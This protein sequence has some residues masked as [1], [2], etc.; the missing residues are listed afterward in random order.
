M[1]YSF[2]LATAPGLSQCLRAFSER[3]GLSFRKVGLA[4][5]LD[6]RGS[7]LTDFLERH[8]EAEKFLRAQLREHFPHLPS[9]LS[10]GWSN[11]IPA[12]RCE[13][14]DTN[15]SVFPA[16]YPAD[17]A[18]REEAVYGDTDRTWSQID[19]R[20]YRIDWQRPFV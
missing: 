17:Q 3:K 18:L 20:A 4:P 14:N 11:E 15:P 5:L 16:L 7:A 1:P 10:E 12:A 2:H 19:N 9:M 8:F 6:Q 13:R